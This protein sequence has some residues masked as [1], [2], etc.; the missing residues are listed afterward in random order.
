MSLYI[1]A[2]QYIYGK[3]LLGGKYLGGSVPRDF[4]EPKTRTI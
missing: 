4:I 3:M 1:I 2:Y